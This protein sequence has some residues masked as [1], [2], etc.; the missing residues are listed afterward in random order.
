MK[1][2]IPKALLIT[3]Q[4]FSKFKTPIK[5]TAGFKE[6]AGQK[7]GVGDLVDT[8]ASLMLTH[9]IASHNIPCKYQLALWQGDQFDIEVNG[10][11]IKTINVK[12]STW[13]PRIDD[14]SKVNYHMAIK[15]SELHK[16]SDIFVQVMVH[17]EPENDSP[18]L[19]YCGWFDTKLLPSNPKTSPYYKEIPNT[20]GS[21][22]LWIPSSDLKSFDE[23][24]V[25]FKS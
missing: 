21:E 19:H 10:I 22:G 3:A 4:E 24:L 16:L 8:V 2:Q 17:L 23:L 12:G 11:V 18:H 1:I 6:Q 9:Y 7:R 25:Q 20:G 15:E 5:R 14:F 13:Q